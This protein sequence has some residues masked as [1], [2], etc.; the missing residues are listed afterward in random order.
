MLEFYRGDY[1]QMISGFSH[2][3]WLVQTSNQGKA[4]TSGGGPCNHLR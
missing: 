3:H 2:F 4:G 1:S